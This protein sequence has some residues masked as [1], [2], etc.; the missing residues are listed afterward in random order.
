[1][2]V[3]KLV[4]GTSQRLFVNSMLS[5]P[6]SC[7]YCYLPDLGFEIGKKD[8]CSISSEEL[9]ALIEN[10]RSF[11][12]GRA[13]TVLSFGCYSECWSSQTRFITKEVIGHFLKGG[14][15]IQFATK[16]YVESNQLHDLV[17][18]VL[19][20]GQ[21][22]VNISSSTVSKWKSYEKG[23]SN[24]EMRF[25]SFNVIHDLGLPAYLYIK[26]VIDGVTI[27]DL[28]YY[29]ELIIEKKV[30][31][32]IVGSI[33]SPVG[34][35]PP[36]MVSPIGDGLLECKPCKD[37]F[38]IQQELEKVTTV[39]STSLEVVEYWRKQERVRNEWGEVVVV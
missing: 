17:C 3:Q 6:S 2:T 20:Q 15:P 11:I 35:L 28:D 14:N 32:V 21:L 19:W 1:M 29:K 36:H 7:A 13:G 24:P 27:L 39:F 30:F 10:N 9:I 25:A 16:R 33:F 22:T 23:T 38:I 37:E 12:C 4:H 8:E 5:C 34:A 26:P 31:G 18:N